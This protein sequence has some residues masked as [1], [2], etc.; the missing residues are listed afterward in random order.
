M[1]FSLGINKLDKIDPKTSLG[2]L[3]KSIREWSLHNKL[4][5]VIIEIIFNN[6]EKLDPIV[7]TTD[8][9]D[10]LN[11]VGKKD[12]LKGGKLKIIQDNFKKVIRFYESYDYR[13]LEYKYIGE[14]PKDEV[15]EM[16]VKS[17]SEVDLL[18]FNLNDN[19]AFFVHD[20]KIRKNCLI[21]KSKKEI[22]K[23]WIDVRNKDQ[24][25][26]EIQYKFLKQIPSINI[27][28]VN[29]NKEEVAVLIEIF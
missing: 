2:E 13:N 3:K 16:Q 25:E 21:F 26:L 9:Y 7:F 20:K 4:N 27:T 29:P 18:A 19:I 6:G 24:N 11:F 22:P 1:K 15:N 28:H 14:F 17:P 12:L 5:N 10:K 8:K 23:E